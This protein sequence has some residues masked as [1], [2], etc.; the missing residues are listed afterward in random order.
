MKHGTLEGLL[1]GR[2]DEDGKWIEERKR[3]VDFRP[4]LRTSSGAH[5]PDSEYH[6]MAIQESLTDSGKFS[7]MLHEGLHHAGLQQ[8]WEAIVE[9]VSAVLSP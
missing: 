4:G 5:L 7:T 1:G 9:W 6:I 2:L 3:W 8:G